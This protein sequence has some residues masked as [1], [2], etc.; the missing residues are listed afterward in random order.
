MQLRNMYSQLENVMQFRLDKIN[1]IKDYFITEI[2]ER[3]AM[4]KIL[5]IN[6]AGL[7]YFDKTLLVLSRAGGS[8]SITSF[9]TVIFA[10]VGMIS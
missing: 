10:P 1:K 6:I 5:S 3:E 4:S 7:D 8:V 2:R 9:A